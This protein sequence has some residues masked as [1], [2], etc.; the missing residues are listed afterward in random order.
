MGAHEP[1][2]GTKERLEVT[3][4]VLREELA[5]GAGD[6]M[7]TRIGGRDEL[8]ESARG[9]GREPSDD[10]GE[11]QMA[12]EHQVVK[13]GEAKDAVEAPEPGFEGGALAGEPPGSSRGIGDV[14]HEERG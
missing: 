10:L 5:G 8:D 13:K 9:A 14:D 12:G 7:D 3:S 2:P 1:E 11:G 6:G 4:I